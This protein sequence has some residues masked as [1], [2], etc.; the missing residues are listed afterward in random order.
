KGFQ[1]YLKK[2]EKTPAINTGFTLASTGTFNMPVT[3]DLDTWVE[4]GKY[5][6]KTIKWVADND[7]SYL[8]W[9]I[10]KD[11]IN[12]SYQFINYLCKDSEWTVVRMRDGEYIYIKNSPLL[13]RKY[14]NKTK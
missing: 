12:V 2:L 9:L 5:R 11:G 4:F 1:K 10:K 7:A 14:K 3:Y 8:L 13:Y 6:N